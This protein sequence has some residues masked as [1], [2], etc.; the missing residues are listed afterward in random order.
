MRGRKY[1]KNRRPHKALLV[2]CEGETEGVYVEALKRHYRLPI[3]IKTKICGNAITDRL[4]K[5]YIGE[6]VADS[7]DDYRVF[8]VYDC[9]VQPIVDKLSTLPGVAILSNPCIELWFILHNIEY[10]HYMDS[11]SILRDLSNCHTAWSSYRKGM[12]SKAQLDILLSNRCTAI[13]RSKQLVWPKNP[14]SNMYILLEA[15]ETEKSAK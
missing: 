10:R 15:L 6:L 9:D 1:K 4:V 8:Y 14:S 7:N 3:T 11:K 13:S 5:Q 2:I 12:L